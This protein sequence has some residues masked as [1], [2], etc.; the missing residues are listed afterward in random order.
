L[1]FHSPRPRGRRNCQCGKR[2]SRLRS[3]GITW[4][5][6]SFDIATDSFR[7]S[8]LPIQVCRAHDFQMSITY[9]SGD[10]ASGQ[11]TVRFTPAPLDL[12]S[13]TPV[14]RPETRHLT[15]DE[16]AVS[17]GILP[18]VF[19]PGLTDPP[20]VGPGSQSRCRR[21]LLFPSQ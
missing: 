17:S 14:L 10:P 4:T 7:E 3:G 9:V 8:S 21:G 6:L 11:Y 15:I 13:A 20:A 16:R 2:F 19:S 18:A 1:A 12:D 5:T